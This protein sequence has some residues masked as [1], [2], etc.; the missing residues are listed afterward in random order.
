MSQA[1]IPTPAESD[2]KRVLLSLIRRNPNIDPRKGRNKSRY[3]SMKASVRSEGVL[4]PILVRPVTGADVPYEVV[5]GNTRYDLSCDVGLTD[6]PAVIREMSDVDARKAAAIENLQ[7]A[8]LTP[9]EEAY[10][11]VVMLTDN[12]NDYAE[13]CRVLGWSRTKLESRVLLSKCCDEVAEALLQG[14]IKL[15]HA[16]L[17]APMSE[18]DQ[19]VIC[20]RVVERGMSVVQTRDRL[21]EMTSAIATARFDTSECQGCMHNSA[22]YTDLFAASLGDAKC[23]NRTCWEQKTSQL[24]EVRKIEAEKEFGMVHT[25]MTL[26]EDGYVLLEESG[27]NGVGTDQFAACTSCTTYGAVVSTRAGQEGRIIGGHCFNKTCHAQHNAS[28]QALIASATAAPVQNLGV[29]QGIQPHNPDS[30]GAKSRSA[31]KSTSAKP[32]EVK[33]AIKRSAFNL[34]SQMAAQAIQANPSF[35]LAIS[36]VSLY[37]D[38]RSDLPA[39]L[40]TRM[41]NVAG[42]PSSLHGHNRA[43]VEAQLALRP[44][45]ELQSFLT[46]MAACTVFR[47]DGSEL[48]QKSVPGAQSLAF[49]KSAGMDPVDHFK[50]T[51]EYMNSLTKAGLIA[52]C[53]V[54]GFAAAYDAVKGEKEFTKLANG[55]VDVLIKA[56]LTFEE[57]SWDGYLPEAMKVSAHDGPATA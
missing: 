52:D 25:D 13:V 29:V 36:I 6:I 7:R 38:M 3:E 11:A 51:E 48:F 56:V 22:Q 14:E 55:K 8:D 30:I 4:Q 47:R 31:S 46:Q 54:S 41:Q 50:M 26:P 1:V 17:L 21:M 32:Q 37:L 43:D 53:K 45:E 44:I 57:F 20:G 28:Y 23:Q 2:A 9:V 42:I 39:E 49:I 33:K 27:I 40:A 16:E 12:N 34:Y 5:F 35:V 24:I 18:E 10:H 15:G 19:R